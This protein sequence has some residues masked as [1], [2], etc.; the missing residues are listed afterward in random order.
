MR[1]KCLKI[2]RIISW[3]LVLLAF[4]TIL[5]GY[6]SSR[7]WFTPIKLYT[8]FHLIFVW[9]LIG[10]SILHIFFS[11]KYLKLKWK[12]IIRGLKNERAYPTNA[13][14]LVQRITKWVIIFL[15]IVT[16]L[17]ALIYYEW[18]ALIFG[19]FFLFRVHLDYEIILLIFVIIHVGIG[20]KFF[21][22]RKKI[23]HWGYDISIFALILSLTITVLFINKLPSLAPFQ[24]KIG[25]KTYKFEPEKVG[26]VRPDLFQ[27]GT[28]FSI[29]DVLVHLNSTGEV[30]LTYHFNATMNTFVI[31]SL[32]NETNWWY[33]AYFSGGYSEF[34]TVRIDHFPWKTGTVMILYQEDPSYID[35]VYSTFEEEVTRLANNNG[36]VIIPTVIIKGRTFNLEF[37][38]VAT[39]PH[40]MRDDIFQ[41]KVITALDVIMSLGDLGYITYELSWFDVL[42]SAR[43]VHNYFVSRINTDE[44]VGRCGFLYEI[45]DED[46]KYP[47]PNYIFLAADVRILTS[48]EYLRFFWDCL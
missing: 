31:D 1:I 42:G 43:Y 23:K 20:L 5:L 44:T 15:T 30:N 38:N 3:I 9:I 36:T 40:N 33:I 35:H 19:D 18:F 17:S 13:L 34:N 41:N 10:F 14:R 45:G 37:Y 2:H 28:S 21:L 22:W 25:D 7:R 6:I 46:F 32:N 24:V 39:T 12:R 47:G 48:P 8:L 27:N 26:T 16:G 29:F 4:I 11:R